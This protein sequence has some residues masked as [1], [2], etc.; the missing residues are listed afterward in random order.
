MQFGPKQ[1][2]MHGFT[3]LVPQWLGLLASPVEPCSFSCQARIPPGLKSKAG[4]IATE[5]HSC[6]G[7]ASYLRDQTNH[8][9]EAIYDIP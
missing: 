3:A 9:I 6:P 2:V 5:Q 4:A 8:K 1:D 7:E